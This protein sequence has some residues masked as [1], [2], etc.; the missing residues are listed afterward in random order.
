MCIFMWNQ[1]HPKKLMQTKSRSFLVYQLARSPSLRWLCMDLGNAVTEVWG[2]Q[3]SSSS[4]V[5]YSIL[6]LINSVNLCDTE[7]A[8]MVSTTDFVFTM[9]RLWQSQLIS[10]TLTRAFYGKSTW[11]CGSIKLVLQGWIQ[12]CDMIHVTSYQLTQPDST[13]SSPLTLTALFEAI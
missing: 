11:G 9:A 3:T 1:V 7:S 12:I 4:A 5:T 2:S 6:E 13:R 8:T 10:V